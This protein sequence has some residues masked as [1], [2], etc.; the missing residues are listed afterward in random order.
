MLAAALLLGALAMVA[1]SWQRPSL[2]SRIAAAVRG[3]SRSRPRASLGW[4]AGIAGMYGASSLIALALLGRSDAL[5]VLPAELQAARAT[6]GISFI[7]PEEI[8]G[9]ALP[10]AGGF[11]GGAL[12]VAVLLR[13]GWRVGPRYRSPAIARTRQEVGAALVL[14]AAAGVAEEV[15]FRLTI[16]L[17]FAIVVGSGVA[18]CVL[19]WALFTAAH[20]Y[21]GRGGMVAVALVGAAL[22]WLYLA[23]GALWLVI[24][25]HAVVD[26][27]ALVIRPAIERRFARP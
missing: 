18:G 19:G 26:A 9:L 13:R 5:L 7:P 16:P 14:A 21:Q 24:A 1:H 6:F 8:T 15:F 25:L 3:G 23:T 2:A 11:M 22:G 20:R 4:A 27:N 12:L 17:L 10:I